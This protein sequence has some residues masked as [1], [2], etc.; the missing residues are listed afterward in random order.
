MA[1]GLSVLAI[2]TTRYESLASLTGTISAVLI[3]IGLVLFAGQSTAF[4]FSGLLL[5]LFIIV[6]HP[7]N[8]G[9]LMRGTERKLGEKV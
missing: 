9:R 2:F 1:L 5:P 4:L 7:D 3:V 6:A 8:I